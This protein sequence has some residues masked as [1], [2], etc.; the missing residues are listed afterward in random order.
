MVKYGVSK[1]SFQRQITQLIATTTSDFSAFPLSVGITAVGV[2]GYGWTWRV[3]TTPTICWLTSS[4][5]A[6]SPSFI[7]KD[8]NPPCV[9]LLQPVKD[10][11]PPL[12]KAFYDGGWKATSLP[13]LMQRIKRAQQIP[14]PTVLFNSQSTL[15]SVRLKWLLGGLWLSIE[16]SPIRH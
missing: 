15:G 3:P 12:K 16:L 1:L 9:A 4:N 5:E 14:I 10:F 13:A 6:S 11:W 7:P 8:A 2:I